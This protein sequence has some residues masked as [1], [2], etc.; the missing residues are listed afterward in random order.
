MISY[1]NMGQTQ[2]KQ[3]TDFK[4]IPII[5]KACSDFP[6]RSVQPGHGDATPG[7]GNAKATATGGRC[8]SQKI[9]DSTIGMQ[10]L[11]HVATLVV[12][13]CCHLWNVTL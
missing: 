2:K 6:R 3:K 13:C 10:G 11:R 7:S 1:S 8:L 9:K 5:P 4:Q 12:A